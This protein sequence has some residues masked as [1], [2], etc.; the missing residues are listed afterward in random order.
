MLVEKAKRPVSSGTHANTA[1]QMQSVRTSL[2]KEFRLALLYKEAAGIEK[3]LRLQ[4][5]TGRD[6][7]VC[8]R[9]ME[10]E[11]RNQTKWTLPH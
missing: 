4:A 3:E 1:A 9:N 11:A 2:S 7:A 6:I 8:E 5:E 10:R